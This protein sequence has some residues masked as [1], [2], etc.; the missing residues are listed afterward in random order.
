MSEQLR[1]QKLKQRTQPTSSGWT[2]DLAYV[3]GI[4]VQA[5]AAICIQDSARGLDQLRGQLPRHA[6]GFVQLI[7]RDCSEGHDRVVQIDPTPGY[8]AD[9]KSFKRSFRAVGSN[10][11]IVDLPVQ[12]LRVTVSVCLS[13]RRIRE[14]HIELVQRGSK[15]R[16]Q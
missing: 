15:S 7:R 2:G 11:S 4:C 13:I 9:S 3:F 16:R 8:T 6:P 12:S 1:H 10:H 14:H 5:A